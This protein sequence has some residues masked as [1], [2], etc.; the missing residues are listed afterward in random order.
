MFPGWMPNTKNAP[1]G[2]LI[3][4]WTA[5]VFTCKRQDWIFAI[6]GNYCWLMYGLYYA[7]SGW[8]GKIRCWMTDSR[9]DSNFC[10]RSDSAVI[11]SFSRIFFGLRV[12]L[13]VMTLLCANISRINKIQAITFVFRWQRA[14]TRQFNQKIPDA[15]HLVNNEKTF[16]WLVG[17][18]RGG[19]CK[20]DINFT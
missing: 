2:S 20:F 5:E 7:S 11:D 10:F 14:G 1:S 9:V 4:R 8:R 6:N 19:S 16:N 12:I 15:R 17:D 3:Q 18:S 13:C